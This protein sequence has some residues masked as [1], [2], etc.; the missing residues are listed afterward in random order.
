MFSSLIRIMNKSEAEDPLSRLVLG[1][2]GLGGVWNPV[3]P[4]ESVNAILYALENGIQWIDTAPAYGDAENFIGEALRSWSGPSPRI[5]TK[6]GRKKGFRV[7]VGEYDYSA[8]AMATSV[9]TSLK[10]LNVEQLDIL[11]LHE[12]AAIPE[13]LVKTAVEEIQ[14]LKM[15]GY[16]R[17]IGLGG[18]Y[19]KS[20]SDYLMDNVFDV[21]MEYNRLTACCIDALSSSLPECNENNVSYWSASPLHMGLLGRKFEDFTM[22]NPNWLNPK[23]I[24]SAVAVNRIAKKYNVSLAGMSMR[25]LFSLPSTFNIVIGPSTISELK[26]TLESINMGPLSAAQL[27]EILEVIR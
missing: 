13:H 8:Y 6:V 22:D 1:T 12:P 25:F 27:E 3:E 10:H 2:A 4:D 9:E 21:V 19:P 16:A 11:F 24:Q 26:S 15:R 23:H 14:C 20:F 18:N 17:Y 5:S 7:D